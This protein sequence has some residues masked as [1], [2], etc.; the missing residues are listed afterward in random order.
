MLARLA[1]HHPAA[2]LSGDVHYGFTSAL[3]R[4][5]DGA[6]TRLAQFTSSAAKNLETKNSVIGMFS[7]LIMRLGIERTRETSG[8]ADLSSTD[9]DRLLAPPP[10]GSVLAWDDTVDVLLGRAARAR[11]QTPT[12][13]ATPV[14]TAYGLAEPDWT[15][16]VDPV[17]DPMRDYAAAT[18]DPP[19]EG[20]DPQKSLTWPL[21]SRTQTW[22]GS[23]GCS[24]A[25]R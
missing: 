13:M 4:V 8:Y 25:C 24:S 10:A 12:V 17:D 23:H 19:W 9:Q 21:H 15:Y 11:A 20:W 14:A 7:E 22:S 1:A 5:E 6:T 3:T 2:V 18:V 16:T